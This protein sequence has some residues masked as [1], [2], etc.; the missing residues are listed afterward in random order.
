[1]KHA[2][3]VAPISLQLVVLGAGAAN[4]EHLLRR[5]IKA[6]PTG[7]IY[8]GRIYEGRSA[9]IPLQTPANSACSIFTCPHYTVAVA[10]EA[11]G[12]EG[13]KSGTGQ[14]CAPEGFQCSD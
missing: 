7:S 12:R 8:S 3:T 4:A 2:L 10:D 14:P 13:D 11:S 5:M 9:Y 1:M 6:Y